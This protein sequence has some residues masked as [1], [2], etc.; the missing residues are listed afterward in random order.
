[1][2]IAILALEREV[3]IS[4]GFGSIAWCLLLTVAV[5]TGIMQV[6]THERP[7]RALVVTFW[8]ELNGP[9]PPERIRYRLDTRRVRL[10]RGRRRSRG[11]RPVS[12]YARLRR[13]LPQAEGRAQE[14]ATRDLVSQEAP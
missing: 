6:V 2:F 11:E 14:D 1:M 10:E 13:P 8:Q 12:L 4:F 7:L 5:T 9:R 3:G